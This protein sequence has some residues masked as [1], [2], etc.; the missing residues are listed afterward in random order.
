M[1]SHMQGQ[2]QKRCLTAHL[3]IKK[4]LLYYQLRLS[5]TDRSVFYTRI[6]LFKTHQRPITEV[7][8]EVKQAS[9]ASLQRQAPVSNCLFTIP[10]RQLTWNFFESSKQGLLGPF[11]YVLLPCDW[12][13]AL[14]SHFV[15][16]LGDW[17]IL[18]WGWMRTEAVHLQLISRTALVFLN[19][20][21]Y[22][23][24]PWWQFCLVVMWMKFIVGKKVFNFCWQK[25]KN[26]ALHQ[27]SWNSSKAE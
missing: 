16:L 7:K 26:M 27:D 2:K 10:S 12:K 21:A 25:H 23:L 15:L 3:H 19:R 6:T 1:W 8:V 11:C 18:E 13:W 20:W 17:T 5:I 24:K 4:E 14:V 22:W 9:V